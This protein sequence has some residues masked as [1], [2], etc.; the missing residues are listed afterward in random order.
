MSN[1]TV[2]QSTSNGTFEV[3]EWTYPTP[4]SFRG[5]IVF[6]SDC[7]ETANTV[8]EQLILDADPAYQD[9]LM[10]QDAEFA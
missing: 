9:W 1:I 6:A 5:K 10:Q 7:F 3:I 2:T 8:C 4:S